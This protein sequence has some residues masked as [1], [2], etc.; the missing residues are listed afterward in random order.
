MNGRARPR[1]P[2]ARSGVAAGTS[3]VVHA[4]PSAVMP[5]H[6]GIQSSAAFE[7]NLRGRWLLDAPLSRSMTS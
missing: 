7:A 5:A 6:A 3:H 4:S 1:I 2:R